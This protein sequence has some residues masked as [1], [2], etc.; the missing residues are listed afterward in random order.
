M[1]DKK[2]KFIKKRGRI[3]PIRSNKKAIKSETIKGVALGALGVGISLA[4]SPVAMKVLPRKF[5]LGGMLSTVFVGEAIAAEGIDKMIE[6]RAFKHRPEQNLK[7]L[8]GGT[9]GV[10]GALSGLG[11]GKKIFNSLKRLRR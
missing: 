8:A 9:I 5:K 3:I 11:Y 4:L 6:S 2:I 1:S 7:N 10:L